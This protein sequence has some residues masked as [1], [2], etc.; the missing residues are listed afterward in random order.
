MN[1]AAILS[2]KGN[3]VE[4]VGPD[5]PVNVAVHRMSTR[6]IGS[7][8]ER[9]FRQLVI[10]GARK[11]GLEPVTDQEARDKAL[12]GV[13]DAE[14]MILVENDCIVRIEAESDATFLP[15]ALA[16][17]LYGAKRS[18]LD[19]DV[20]LFDGG[21]DDVM[22]VRLAPQHGREEAHHFPPQY[23]PSFMIPGAVGGNSHRRNAAMLRMPLIHWR[24]LAFVDQLLQGGEAYPLKVDG[25]MSFGH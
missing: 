11:L 23:R 4:V 25:R 22:A 13:G 24:Q 2:A 10:D 20:E 12:V 17:Q 1:V 8:G 19:V 18:P 9:N 16:M 21:D 6:G 7:L 3:T 5:V 15:L 14:R